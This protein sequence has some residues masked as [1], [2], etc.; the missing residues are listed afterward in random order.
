[1][2]DVLQHADW[3]TTFATS[4]E[5]YGLA[6]VIH[7]SAMFLSV[8][9]IVLLDLRILGLAERN[10]A[11]SAVA[12]QLRPCT[13]IGLGSAVVSGFLLFTSKAGW[14]VAETPFRIKVLIVVPAVVSALVIEWRVPKWDRMPVVPVTARLVAVMSI[15]LWLSAILV[16]VEIPALTGLG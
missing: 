6:V 8:G 12:A 9:T 4:R 5:L 2:W 10:H 13:W 3:V 1:M 7:Y 15:L 16:S 14:Y 11:L